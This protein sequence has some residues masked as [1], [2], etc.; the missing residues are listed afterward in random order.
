[1]IWSL[2]VKPKGASF[3]VTDLHPFVQRDGA[4]R[5]RVRPGRGVLLV[6][7]VGGWNPPDKGRIFRVTDPEAM[8]NPAVAE[9]KKLLAEGFEKKSV[10]EL[11]KLLGHPHQQVRQEAQFELAAAGRRRRDR[12]RSRSVAEGVE[13][14]TRP[15][16]RGL[17]ARDD[18]PDATGRSTPQ[19]AVRPTLADGPGRRGPRA[20]VAAQVDSAGSCGDEADAIRNLRSRSGSTDPEPRVRPP[21]RPSYGKSVAMP[22]SPIIP[23]VRADVLRARCS[24]C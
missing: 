17:G 1:M 2:A 16:A 20:T 14:P 12:R 4:D 10:E 3:E 23:R 7:W 13:E 9:A 18:R 21:P 19:L 22:E 15:A 8:K 5:L 6:D 11:A 24:T